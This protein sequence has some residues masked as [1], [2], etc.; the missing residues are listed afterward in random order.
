MSTASPV[1]SRS[2]YDEE[3]ECLMNPAADATQAE[4]TPRQKPTELMSQK[5]SQTHYAVNTAVTEAMT[6]EHAVRVPQALQAA[7]RRTMLDVLTRMRRQK[8]NDLSKYSGDYLAEKPLYG[9]LTELKTHDNLT[10]TDEAASFLL[11]NTTN[12]GA[13][14]AS[15]LNSGLS[16]SL[17]HLMPSHR[18]LP[19]ELEPQQYT[20]EQI[21]RE[22]SISDFDDDNNVG[23]CQRQVPQ[24]ASMGRNSEDGHFMQRHSWNSAVS[25]EATRRHTVHQR[26]WAKLFGCDD[27]QQEELTGHE[28]PTTMLSSEKCTR[29]PRTS[30]KSS[31]PSA[32]SIK[33]LWTESEGGPRQTTGSR[34]SLATLLNE[35]EARDDEAY[36]RSVAAAVSASNSD[37]KSCRFPD[38]LANEEAEESRMPSCHL[39]GKPMFSTRLPTHGSSPSVPTAFA[40]LH[41]ATKRVGSRGGTSAVL[42]QLS[43]NPISA[44]V[45]AYLTRS[46]EDWK[47]DAALIRRANEE[48][49]PHD[50]S[51]SGPSLLETSGVQLKLLVNVVESAFSLYCIRC[52]VVW[53]DAQASKE[54]FC[55]AHT[56]DGMIQI[57]KGYEEGGGGGNEAGVGHNVKRPPV[58]WTVVLTAATF[59]AIPIV[60]GSHLYLARPFFCYPSIRAIVA[61]LNITSD[62]A[63]QRLQPTARRQRRP[64]D[65]ELSEPQTGGRAQSGEFCGEVLSFGATTPERRNRPSASLTGVSPFRAYDPFFNPPTNLCCKN[66]VALGPSNS[67]SQGSLRRSASMPR[68]TTMNLEGDACGQVSA[69][70]SQMVAHDV[71][72]AQFPRGPGEEWDV[73]LEVLVAL[74]PPRKR[75]NSGEPEAHGRR[76]NNPSLTPQRTCNEKYSPLSS[77]S[78]IDVEKPSPLAEAHARVGAPL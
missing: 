14:N 50:L 26:T 2:T 8:E 4:K 36:A 16:R 25:E 62:A 48:N 19:G 58:T 22:D 67:M 30:T 13:N 9:G 18:G 77:L 43:E 75:T 31:R 71:I 20:H 33:G 34:T 56:A 53:A 41:G 32:G 72:G 64:R 11:A 44:R 55:D 38:L 23:G 73:P 40:V 27:L 3:M 61:S 21:M 78:S 60:V 74:C 63:V 7:T 68:K 54:L 12:M 70:R 37:G 28:D 39:V 45:V 59:R 10:V 15:T 65:A 17:R 1:S 35:A 46:F 6:M 66:T 47:L 29:A 49:E 69:S 52:E 57:Q 42:K 51:L 5:R 76:T 24:R